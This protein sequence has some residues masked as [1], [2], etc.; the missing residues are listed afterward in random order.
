TGA[1]LDRIA[2][3]D[4]RLNAYQH[5]CAESALATAAAL[6]ALLAAGTDLGPLMGV[7]V[8][9]K[10]IFAVTGTPTTAGSAVDVSDLIGAEGSFVGMLRRAG[11]VTLGKTRTV[12]F[13]LG[14]HGTNEVHGT[15]VNPWDA[16]TPRAP[17]GSSA[18]T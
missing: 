15:P 5:L 7:P 1:Y 4:G 17:G 9:V 16:A 14:G 11:C 18:G 6:D 13:A 10:D 12:E 2:A 8:A 3:Y